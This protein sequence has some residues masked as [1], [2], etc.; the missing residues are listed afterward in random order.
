[1][2][3]WGPGQGHSQCEIK[4]PSIYL[5]NNPLCL[6]NYRP[7]TL[8]SERKD[9]MMKYQIFLARINVATQHL[10]GTIGAQQT[11]HTAS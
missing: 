1:M 11:V 3:T 2:A 6:L 4:P 10:N 8:H 7:T 5:L 9:D